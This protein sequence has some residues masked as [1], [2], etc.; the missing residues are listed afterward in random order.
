LSFELKV[1]TIVE[2]IEQES[3]D[4]ELDLVQKENKRL[5][6]VISVMK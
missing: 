3:V 4:T 2:L 1:K 5:Q 6:E